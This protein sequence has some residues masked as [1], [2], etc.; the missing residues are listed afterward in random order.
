MRGWWSLPA[1]AL[2]IS[3]CA[4]D[5]DQQPSAELEQATVREARVDPATLRTA[6]STLLAP[7]QA[8]PPLGLSGEDWA[9]L[10]KH[11]QS[12]EHQPIFVDGHGPRDRARDFLA[13][14]CAV[15]EDGLKPSDYDLGAITL[16]L[17]KVR[18]APK[19]AAVLATAELELATLF[20]HFG[21]DL[22]GGRV[23]PGKA[24][25]N[26]TGRT[27][28]AAALLATLDGDAEVKDALQRLRPPHPEYQKLREAL[29]HYRRLEAEGGWPSIPRGKTVEPG[30]TDPRLEQVRQLL[31]RTG[32]LKP[33]P[34]PAPHL[35]D[36]ALVEAV[37]AFQQRHGLAPDGRIGGE[38]LSSMRVPVARRISQLIANL[39]RWRW[40]PE[41]LGDR[42]LLVNVPAFQLEAREGDRRVHQMRVIVGLPDWATP[43]F[44][45]QVEA[46]I[47]Q[48]QWYVPDRILSQD[49][50][51]KLQEDAAFANKAGLRVYGSD[52]AEVDPA[53]VDWAALDPAAAVPYR[54]QQ[55]PGDGNPLGQVKFTLPNRYS[56]YLH[57]TPNERLFQESFRSYS[58]GCVRVE[59]PQELAEFVLAGTEGWGSGEVQAEFEAG[60]KSRHVQPA[61]P[62]RVYLTYFTAFVADDGQVQ[63]RTDLYRWDWVLI[64][65]LGKEEAQPAPLCG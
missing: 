15:E 58:H 57:D 27:L 21:H 18:Q 33:G 50:L 29:A 42:S 43:V 14:L 34:A 11:Y 40:M 46:V 44:A 10:R 62:P 20:V 2:L 63:F 59:R 52:G 49:I 30:G 48:P 9:A 39:E 25:W 60:G 36:P 4:G 61:S 32:E 41:S 5:G 16:T 28:D 17:D 6:L 7:E 35:Y 51:P 12:R 23:P 64:R 13:A 47:F 38:T 65:Q 45:S 19:D 22:S 31:Q 56:V 54:F 8:P 3:A 53:S 55:P 24:G 26:L 1:A 37:K